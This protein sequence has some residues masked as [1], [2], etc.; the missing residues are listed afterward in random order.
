MK[1]LH[2]FPDTNLFIQ[3]RALEE[4]DWSV[5]A[6]FDEVH[7]IVCRPVQREI[8][9]QKGKGDDRIGRRARQAHSQF[10]KIILSENGLK[11][12]RETRPQVRL[13]VEPSYLP[14]PALADRLDYTKV[15]DEIVG[16]VHAHMELNPESDTRLLTHDSGPMASARMLSVPFVSIPDNWLLQP[17]S[18]EEERENI[19]L[20]KELAR[21]KMAE[22]QFAISCFDNE[23]SEINSLKF[24]YS[25]YEPLTENEISTY[26]DSLK[27]QFPLTTDFGPHEPMERQSQKLA[28]VFLGMK[29]TFTPA[30]EQEIAEYTKTVYP[31]W[32]ERCEHILR[33][34]HVSLEKEADPLVFSFSAVNGG[35][36]PGRD[37]LVTI[38]AKGN[39]LVRPP[40]MEDDDEDDR[41]QDESDQAL[42]FPLP[43][44]PPEGKWTTGLDAFFSN[45]SSGLGRLL[46][47]MNA[48]ARPLELPMGPLPGLIKR[49]RDPN[50]FY[51]KP[52]PSKAP[53]ESF[54][55]ECEQW[56]HGIDEEI[57]K[58]E[59]CVDENAQEIRGAL[60]CRIHAENL[61]TP[62]EKTIPVR[63]RARPVSARTFA[64]KLIDKLLSSS[65]K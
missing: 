12:I 24:E 52:N 42:S 37:A 18:N 44:R 48:F 38:T 63:G 21:L 25:I 29:E 1:I 49:R 56:R 11:L 64:E 65:G 4:F 13:L 45:E 39:V 30:S 51:Y 40:K 14:N 32:V 6:E 15:D 17:E 60:E 3:C 59:L 22:P 61:S 47:N 5:W 20:K 9:N 36:R 33:Q 58:G 10:R 34:L 8:D 2:L 26:M 19:R 53:A 35:S 16:C 55:L 43:P 41:K 31:G 7:L 62:V 27:E 23:G 46:S 54:S 28:S 50:Q 57:F